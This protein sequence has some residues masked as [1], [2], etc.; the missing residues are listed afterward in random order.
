MFGNKMRSV[1]I[2][3]T[4]GCPRTRMDLAWLFPYFKANGWQVTYRPDKAD[5][6]VA[7][8]CGFND[9]REEK[10]IQHL[11]LLKETLNGTPFIVIGCLAG[12]NA[13]RIKEQLGA[14]PIRPADFSLLDQSIAAKIP[15]K[16]VPPVNNT[17]RFMHTA[18]HWRRYVKRPQ[19]QNR[20][21][22][23]KYHTMQG[24]RSLLRYLRIERFAVQ[25]FH[26]LKRLEPVFQIRVARGCLEECTYCVIRAAAGK[27]RSKPLS[28]ILAE[29]DCGLDKGY[30]SFELIGED[31]GPYGLDI[32][33]TFPKLLVELFHRRENFKLT[34]IDVNIRYIIE[35]KE[36]LKILLRKNSTRIRRIIVPVQSGSDKI[37]ASMQRCYTSAEVKHC[38][39]DLI[40]AVPSLI[41]ETHAL[42]GFPGET[43]SDF[44][45]TIELL[46]TLKFDKLQV[47][48]YTDRTGTPA[49]EM[50][51]KVS[52]SEKQ[53]RVQYLLHEFPQAVASN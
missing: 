14:T 28:K 2:A 38:L 24:L 27:I 30:K 36:E 8:A 3:H 48:R 7:S 10:S 33:T 20:L 25:M 35:Y 46:K 17:R 50:V 45:A 4:T 39:G 21:D 12:I 47:Y 26:S 37:L 49:S 51:E 22:A 34:L 32:G 9:V 43:W 41:L 31:L 44:L 5:L 13:T 29:F 16:E 52:E 18:S 42:V 23:L 6:V 40:K 15:L 53:D 19:N 1:C 11:M